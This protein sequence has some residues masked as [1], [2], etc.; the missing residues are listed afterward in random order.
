MNQYRLSNEEK[1]SFFKEEVREAVRKLAAENFTSEELVYIVDAEGEIWDQVHG[2]K[3]ASELI[4]EHFS[5]EE[6]QVRIAKEAA[7]AEEAERL[8]TDIKPRVMKKLRAE[9]KQELR[10]E[11]RDRSNEVLKLRADLARA[12]RRVNEELNQIKGQLAGKKAEVIQLKQKLNE[13]Y[14]RLGETPP[15]TLTREAIKAEK[16]Q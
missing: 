1:A 15:P 8:E 12:E 2:S 9:A 7:E 6:L 11:L 14:G 4:T 13:L 10:D 3:E 16:S 5:E